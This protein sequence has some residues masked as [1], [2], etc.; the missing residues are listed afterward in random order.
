MLDLETGG[1]WGIAPLAAGKIERRYVE[2]TNVLETT[3]HTATGVAIV[4]DFLAAASEDEKRQSLHPEHELI[5]IVDCA[6]GEV[7]LVV[8]FDPR[9]DYGRVATLVDC[10]PLG[11]RLEIGSRLVTLRS[12]VGFSVDPAGGLRAEARLTAGQRLAFSLTFSSEA[13]AVVPPL[14]ELI[15]RKREAALR[16]WSSWAARARYDGP[17]RG[18][19][20]RSALALKLLSHAPSGAIV[21]APTTSLPERLG[22]DLNYDYRYCWL[23]DAAFTTRALLG[24]GYVEDA[25]AFVG[26]LLHATRLTRPKLGVLYDVWGEP[27]PGEE[28]LPQWSGYAGSRPVRIGNAA[29][30]QVQIDVYGESIDAVARLVGSDGVLDRETQSMLCGFGEHVCRH[31]RDPDNGIWEARDELRHYT[32]SRHLCWVALDRLLAMHARGQLGHLP[33]ERFVENRRLIAE[34]IESHAWNTDL[35]SYSDVLGGGGLDATLLRLA[36]FGF[37]EASSPRMLQTHARIQ[38][39][40]GAAPGLL[41]RYAESRAKGEGA[42]A[43]CSFW[44]AEFLARGGGTLAAAEDVFDTALACANDVGLFAEEIDPVTKGA[45]GNFPQ[46]FTHVGVINAALSLAERTANDAGSGSVDVRRA[47]GGRGRP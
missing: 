46:A 21:A 7:A 3:F 19:V 33:V 26:W 30:S 39:R 23:R 16:W 8:Y 10:G 17:H 31:W 14:G 35:G 22:G 36:F 1:S 5:R 4:T 29:A 20:V 41:Y 37:A 40:L 25:E 15:E 38:E 47:V 34:E 9:P 13:P 42:F 43:L 18:A 28:I 24:L 32:N 2:H 44:V 12:D 6:R 27:R 45:L 11:V